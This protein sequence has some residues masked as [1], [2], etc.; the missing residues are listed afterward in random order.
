MQCSFHGDV[1]SE[2]ETHSITCKGLRVLL[3]SILFV[4][5][6]HVVGACGVRGRSGFSLCLSGLCRWARNQT[7]RA[8]AAATASPPP[9]APCAAPTASPTCPP[10]SP[11]APERALEPRRTSLRS[12]PRDCLLILTVISARDSHLT[13]CT[14]HK[15]LPDELQRNFSLNLFKYS[16]YFGIKFKVKSQYF[17]VLPSAITCW[18]IR[19]YCGCFEIRCRLQ[20]SVF[21]IQ[22]TCRENSSQHSSTK[23]HHYCCLTTAI[24]VIL[25]FV[26]CRHK[27]HIS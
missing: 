27:A 26:K 6:S 20:I 12:L 4:P 16:L 3:L 21:Y 14:T 8:S 13:D 15:K 25:F 1:K 17:T 7:L 11:A 18:A 5:R 24:I 9:S 23:Y 10:A 22:I 2:P 19:F